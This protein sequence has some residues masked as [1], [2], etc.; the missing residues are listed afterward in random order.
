M[1][2]TALVAERTTA[3]INVK[4]VGVSGQ[5]YLYGVFPMNGAWSLQPGNYAF[6]YRAQD[7]QWVILYCGQTESLA[8]RF[9]N[10]EE[11]PRALRVGATHVLAHVTSGGL[12]VRQAEERDLIAAYNPP[13]NKHHRVAPLPPSIRLPIAS[14]LMLG[15]GAPRRRGK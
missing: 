15:L 1:S 5:E 8:G 9:P 2:A 3:V 14:S 6:S 12:V 7:G 4:L 13:L 10:H 11:W